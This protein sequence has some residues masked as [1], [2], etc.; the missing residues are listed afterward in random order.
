MLAALNPIYASQIFLVTHDWAGIFA[1]GAVFL[2]LTGAEA[3][4]AD[5]GHF[6]RSAITTELVR[7]GVASFGI[8]LFRPRRPSHFS[9]RGTGKSVLPSIPALD[10]LSDDFASDCRDRNRISSGDMRRFLPLATGHAT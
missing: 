3:L 7:V 5:M 9:P 4:Y 1:L 8:E 10:A 2:A 6:G